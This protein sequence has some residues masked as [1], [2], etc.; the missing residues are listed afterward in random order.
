MPLGKQIISIDEAKRLGETP[1]V[2][3]AEA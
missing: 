3:V 2:V 1:T